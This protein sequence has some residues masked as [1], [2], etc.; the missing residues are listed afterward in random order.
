MET[1]L[2]TAMQYAGELLIA[3]VALVIRSIEK[4]ILIKKNRK[5]WEEGER[6]SKIDRE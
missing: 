1:I 6:Y 2:T 4:K 5:K 3:S